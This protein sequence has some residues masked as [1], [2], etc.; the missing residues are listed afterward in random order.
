MH[1]VI[2]RVYNSKDPA[3]RP[4]FCQYLAIA[5]PSMSDMVRVQDGG[6]V[7]EPAWSEQL[8]LESLHKRLASHVAETMSKWANWSSNRSGKFS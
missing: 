5:S 6:Q 8:A 3:D 1:I 2:M 7:G 4:R